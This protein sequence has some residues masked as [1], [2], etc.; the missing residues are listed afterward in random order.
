MNMPRAARFLSEVEPDNQI[1]EDV[2]DDLGGEQ[3]RG[4]G[5]ESETPDRGFE[6]RG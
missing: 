2:L 3:L 4:S 6:E 1:Q 5:F